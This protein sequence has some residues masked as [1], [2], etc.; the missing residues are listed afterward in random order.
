MKLKRIF[1]LL[2]TAF[3]LFSTVGCDGTDS[4][5][6]YFQLS[7]KPTT[8]DPQ[9]AQTDTELLIVKNIFEGLLR[10]DQDGNI[11]CGVAESYEKSGL[12]YVFNLRK[13]AKWHN[14]DSITADDFVFA[15]KRAVDPNTKS[16]FVSRLYCIQNA[17]EINSGKLGT[18]SLGVTAQGDQTLKITLSYEDAD[19]E[20]TL[21]TAIAMPCNQKFFNESNGKYGMFKDN[22]LSN[23]SYKLSKWAKDIFGIRLYR[24]DEY[25]GLI[26]SKNAAVFLSYSEELTT[27]E[28]LLEDDTDM[29]FIPSTQ[30]D[31][32]KNAGYTVDSY[33]N[34]CWFL[35]LSDGFSSGIRKSLAILANG[36]VFEK[37]LKTGY[38]VAD[39]IYPPALN[40]TVKASGMQVYD[41][42]SAKQLYSGEIVKLTDKKFPSDV[43]LYYYDDGFSKTVVTDIV[44]HWQNNLGAFVNIEAVSSPSVLTSQL[45]TQTYGMSI[46]PVSADSPEMTEYLEKFGIAYNGQDLTQLQ[47][48]ILKSNN[49]VPIMFQSTSIAYRSNLTNVKFEHGNG[50]ID[51]AFIVKEDD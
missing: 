17:K 21:T 35:T 41:L 2:L 1:S 10:K 46:F 34:I 39:S 20:E 30:I 47:I 23:G 8:L 12:T 40:T 42:Q 11:V 43:V 27:S 36:Q 25:T 31:T 32:L 7:E 16:P 22:I 24:N 13:D 4:A 28:I 37:S 9:T 49:V 14:G 38:T 6:I 45:Q 48:N 33:D 5:Y 29:A 50:C 18:D 44:G 51:F 15:L 3:L 19:F 26:K